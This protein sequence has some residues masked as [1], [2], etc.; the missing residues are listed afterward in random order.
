MYVYRKINSAL[1]KN[2]I[3]NLILSDINWNIES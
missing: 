1:K 2:T 3:Q